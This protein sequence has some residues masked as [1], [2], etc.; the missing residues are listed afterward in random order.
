MRSQYQIDL[1][2][3]AGP[4]DLL[5]HL[6]ERQEFDITS[7]SLLHVTEQYLA[8][9]EQLKKNR[10]ENLI[11]FLVVAARLALIKSRALLPKIPAL[12]GE[13]EEED[14]AEALVRQLRQYKRFKQA[15]ARLGEREAAGLRTYLRVAPPPKLEGQLDMTGITAE[16][17][18]TAVQAA[19]ARSETKTDSVALVKPRQ[20]TIEGQIKQLRRRLGG[21]GRFTFHELLPQK[22]GRLEIAVTLLAVLELLKR[23]EL[24]VTQPELF[25][26]IEIKL[27]D[28]KNR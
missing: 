10:I 18:L 4:L 16:T 21:Y 27:H 12:P 7:I 1:P 2:A 23:R 13:E 14:P 6:I 25:G 3:F 15:A 5:L 17:L 8:Q 26:P 20:I 28:R 19:L 24:T 11:D 22:S 9:I